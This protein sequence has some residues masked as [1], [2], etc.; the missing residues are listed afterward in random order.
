MAVV[1]D[2]VGFLTGSPMESTRLLPSAHWCI[3]AL[4][5]S[6]ASHGISCQAL[7]VNGFSS[8]TRAP[9]RLQLSQIFLTNCKC[10][11]PIANLRIFVSLGNTWDM[12]VNGSPGKSTMVT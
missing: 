3:I 4:T 8:S 10:F 12:F 7:D 1:R 5:N 2:L 11:M 9:Q 6:E